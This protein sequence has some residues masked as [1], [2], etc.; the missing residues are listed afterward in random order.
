MPIIDPDEENNWTDFRGRLISDY[1]LEELDWELRC[2]VPFIEEIAHNRPEL[3]YEWMMAHPKL[4]K[5]Q[6][7]PDF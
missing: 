1:S 7:F 4:R 5:P 6:Y 2:M 3:L